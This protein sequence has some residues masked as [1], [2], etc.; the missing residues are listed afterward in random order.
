MKQWLMVGTLMIMLALLALASLIRD[1][2]TLK[3]WPWRAAVLGFALLAGGLLGHA[4]ATD[5]AER[6]SA[7]E[8]GRN[9][10][11][12]LRVFDDKGGAWRSLAHGTI[13]HGGQF[14]DPVRSRLP[15]TYYSPDSGVGL[16]VA[17]LPP[18]PRRLGIVGLGAGSLAVYGRRGD[19]VRFYEINP[20]VEA[21]ARRDFTFLRDC[22]ARVEVVMGDARL[23]LEGE[24]PEAYDLLAVDAF[25]SD[26]IPVH[27]LTGEAFELYL[28]HLAPGGLLAVHISNRYLDLKPVVQAAALRLGLAARVVDTESDDATGVYGST[29]ILLAHSEAAFSAAPFVESEDVAPLQ[30]RPLVWRDDFSNL[31]RILK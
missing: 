18:G 8:R 27:L 7:V 12:T 16:A 25:S 13:L 30:A 15:L 14:L 21:F 24:P 1:R 20:L 19:L 6:R 23:R 26:A 28:H 2:R 29:W 11:G 17:S 3:P 4:A 31:F 22:P 10:Y 9:F 5:L